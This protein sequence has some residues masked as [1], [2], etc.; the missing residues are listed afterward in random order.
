[1]DTMTGQQTTRR[2]AAL[3]LLRGNRRE[4][5]DCRLV[6]EMWN[7]S[8]SIAYVETREAEDPYAGSVSPS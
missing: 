8:T 6:P 7:I 2:M 3:S 1:M 5:Q 4:Y